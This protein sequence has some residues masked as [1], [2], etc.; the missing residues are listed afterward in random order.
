MN[1]ILNVYK[2]SEISSAATV[3]KVRRALGYRHVGHMGTLDPIGEGVLLVG[4]GKGA[5]LFDYY[6][7]K[8]KT[9]EAA[10]RFGITSDTLDITGNVTE[11]TDNIPN[12]RTIKDA[13]NKFIGVQ[14]QLPPAYSAKSVGG[15]RAYELARKGLAPELKPAVITV[16]RFDMIKTVGENEYLF[17]IDCSAGTY[18]RSLCRDLAESLGSL[19]L[20]TSIKRTRCGT[21]FVE[22]SV[23]IENITPDIVLSLDDALSEMPRFDAPDEAYKTIINGV[24]YKT[25]LAP[26]G[27]FTLYCRNELI[28]I[29]RVQS[30]CIKI[31]TYLKGDLK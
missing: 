10:F 27:D 24:P 18:I 15:V 3:G 4:V 29:A 16:N 9:Y 2:P 25:E 11:K 17:R 20:M 23:K 19:A 30:S 26:E 7:G 12:E 21:F 22:N 6:L 31:K 8:S 5:R 1:G 13:L 14:E 28:G